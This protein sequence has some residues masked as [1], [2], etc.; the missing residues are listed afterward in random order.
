MGSRRCGSG[1]GWKGGEE[2]EGEEVG[3]TDMWVPLFVVWLTYGS[4]VFCF[5]FP[6]FNFVPFIFF[7]SNNHVSAT[8]IPRGTK[9]PR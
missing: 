5:I 7:G 4:R 6:V 9:V 8:S 1:I 3:P 2:G